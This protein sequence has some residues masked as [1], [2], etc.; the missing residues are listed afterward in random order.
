M[1]CN[2]LVGG[3]RDNWWELSAYRGNS[4][5]VCNVNNNGNANN[6]GASYSYGVRPLFQYR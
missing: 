1:R 3:S 6:N 2:C 5:N 4:S